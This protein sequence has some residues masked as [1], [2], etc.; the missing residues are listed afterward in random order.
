MLILLLSLAMAGKYDPDSDCQIV[1]RASSS[2]PDGVELADF[3]TEV[4]YPWAS[5]TGPTGAR[6]QAEIG[7]GAWD[8]WNL[9]QHPD[10]Q[11]RAWYSTQAPD[12]RARLR[13]RARMVSGI[14]P[15]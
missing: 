10:P 15:V 1:W 8:Y 2:V 13:Q 4:W 5:W 9:T 7:A 14:I 11:H 12:V 3:G 6:A